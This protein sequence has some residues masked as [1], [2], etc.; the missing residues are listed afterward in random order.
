MTKVTLSNVDEGIFAAPKHMLEIVTD[1]R[2]DQR[3][4]SQ[5]PLFHAIECS[6]VPHQ[7]TAELDFIV[8]EKRPFRCA[9]REGNAS[10]RVIPLGKILVIHSYWQPC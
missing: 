4:V 10:V 6:G 3:N 1:V 2:D 9:V 7:H 5:N 8:Q